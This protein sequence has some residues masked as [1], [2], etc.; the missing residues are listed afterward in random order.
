MRLCGTFRPL[1]DLGEPKERLEAHSDACERVGSALLS[2]D[3][4]DD[5]TDLDPGLAERLDRLHGGPSGSDHVLD[6]AGQLALFIGPLQAIAG[7]VGLRL[8]ADDQERKA[9]GQRRRCRERN[10]AELGAGKPDRVRLEGVGR[11]CN[12]LPQR[13]EQLGAGLEAVLVEVEARAAARTEDEVALEI[14]VLAKS[15]GELLAVHYPRAVE[16]S[17]RA[18]DSSRSAPGAPSASETID[19]SPK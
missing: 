6:E 7:A 14:R 11:L 1:R 2:I 16:S 12:R 4:A 15:E 9:R 10:R 5:V 19:P 13:A 17:S 18:C 8:L 3:H